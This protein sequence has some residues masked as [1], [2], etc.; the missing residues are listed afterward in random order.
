MQQR[1]EQ[2]WERR[3]QG[4]HAHASLTRE[5]ATCECATRARAARPA[6]LKPAACG[7]RRSKLLLFML[8][9]PRLE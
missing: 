6:G 3:P 9:L 2:R 1:R 7:L 4:A 8:G 5:C